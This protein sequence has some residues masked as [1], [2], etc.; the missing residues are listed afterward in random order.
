MRGGKAA[1]QLC[2]QSFVR[3]RI[4]LLIS[5]AEKKSTTIVMTKIEKTISAIHLMCCCFC[6]CFMLIFPLKLLPVYNSFELLINFFFAL[7]SVPNTNI[8]RAI[9]FQQSKIYAMLLKNRFD[10]TFRL[11]RQRGII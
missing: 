11:F 2:D 4:F 1:E 10:L 3:L 6:C 7:F 5:V 8:H 9:E